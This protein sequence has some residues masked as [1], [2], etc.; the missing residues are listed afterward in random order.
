[1]LLLGVSTSAQ[2]VHEMLPGPALTRISTERFELPS[3][4]ESL[5]QVRRRAPPGLGAAA[6]AHRLRVHR[7]GRATARQAVVQL[8]SGRAAGVRLGNK[9]F[10]YLM[11]TYLAQHVSIQQ[12]ARTVHVRSPAPASSPARGADGVTRRAS[13]GRR[14]ATQYALMD[15]YFAN[16]LAVLTEPWGSTDRDPAR[17]ATLALLTPLHAQALRLLPSLQRCARGG[18]PGATL[19]RGARCC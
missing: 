17:P 15:H 12:L 1:M 18:P 3:A 13:D 5:D 6:R 7:A 11:D 16:P 9:S 19:S 4:T 2:V 8:F 10:R 14:G